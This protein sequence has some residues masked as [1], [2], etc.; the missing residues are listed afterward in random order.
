MPGSDTDSLGTTTDRSASGG[1]SLPELRAS[2]MHEVKSHGQS[3][4]ELWRAW[5]QEQEWKE[6]TEWKARSEQ[7][8]PSSRVAMPDCELRGSEQVQNSKAANVNKAA[9]KFLA[10]E[11]SK[12]A[13]TRYVLSGQ[14]TGWSAMAKIIREYDEEKV[15]DCQ[16]DIDTLLVFVSICTRLL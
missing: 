10:E 1:L 14:P 2:E 6:W 13:K 16:D 5:R 11:K 7:G 8:S 9:A 12:E 3:E 4:F 15:K